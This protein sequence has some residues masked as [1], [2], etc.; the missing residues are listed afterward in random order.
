MATT[1]YL[2]P[3]YAASLAEFGRPLGLPRSGGTLLVRAIPGSLDLDAIGP[4]PLFCCGDWSKLPEDLANLP[5]NLVSVV[6]V[7]DPFASIDPLTLEG[8]FSHGL[9]RYKDHHIIDLE[10]S[11]EDSACSHHL[12]NARWALARLTVEEIE[13]PRS[14]LDV[15]SGL[16]RE[17]ISRH[18]LTGI[19]RFSRES[20]AIQLRVPGL[21]AFQARDDAGE[22]VGMVLW[23]CQGAVGYYHLA[24][25]SPRG[26]AAKASYALFWE[27]ADRL[28]GR[29]RWLS[30]GAGAGGTSDAGD[31]L[32]RFKRG[33]SPLTRPV[34]L[35]RHVLNP[36][37]YAEL[38]RG[39]PAGGF[40]P[41]YRA[42]IATVA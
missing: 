15:W 18:G 17:L 38:H 10:V 3:D 36:G 29:V 25:Y 27:C 5:E 9:T 39:R 11:L 37:L 4:Y 1:G 33:W 12:R 8:A 40:F 14:G 24:A 28:R 31:G 16:Y 26:Y 7:T 19:S 41:A 23:Y 30:L 20:F 22:V 6:L 13:E 42:P 21:A 35:G 2:N 34:Y 32:T